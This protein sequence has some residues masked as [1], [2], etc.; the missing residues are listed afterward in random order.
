MATIQEIIERVDDTKI[1]AFTQKTKLA[2][3]G[4]LDGK[5]AADVMLMSIDEIRMLEYKYP[6]S[7]EAEPLVGY[8]HQDVY[9]YWLEAKIDY[10]NGEYN[11]YQNSM[12]MYNQ[13]YG[14]FVRWF[15]S[16]YE[17]VRGYPEAAWPAGWESPPYYISAYG[18][19]VSK[20]YEGTLEQWLESLIGPQGE[21]GAPFL[22]ENFTAEQ[23]EALRGPQGI[24]GAQ[25]IQGP[26]GERGLTG[27]SGVVSPADGFFT[28]SV[29]TDGNLW[30]TSRDGNTNSFD[31]ESETGN[32]YVTVG[33]TKLIIGNVRGPQGIQGIPGEP[34]YTPVKGKDYFDGEDGQDGADGTNGQSIFQLN[35]E[36]SITQDAAIAYNDI[37]TSG[38]DVN[39][40]D[41]LLSNR[42]YL[43]ETTKVDSNNK[44]Q[45]RHFYL[46]SS[47]QFGV[48]RS[49]P[50]WVQEVCPPNSNPGDTVVTNKYLWTYKEIVRTSF[51]LF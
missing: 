31:Y 37:N 38:K 24:Q 14:N 27:E 32:L 6:D 16:T 17:P 48:T 40:G 23:L 22:Y 19:A 13:H 49:M 41:L 3:I 28:L 10:A 39:I 50:G 51:C 21:Q 15:A 2:W 7:L 4:E 45:I 11:K 43:D 8:P 44:I 35:S 18:L 42:G 30:V 1:N 26:R 47:E 33:G 34:G 20:G 9:V 12:E 46:F 25:G 29:D 36:M 5:I